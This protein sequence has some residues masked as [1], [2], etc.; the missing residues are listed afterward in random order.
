MLTFD[1]EPGLDVDL[2]SRRAAGLPAPNRRIPGGVRYG[3]RGLS[4]SHDARIKASKRGYDAAKGISGRKR[5]VAVDSALTI[6]I[7]AASKQHRDA[8]RPLM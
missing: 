2:H 3:H 7:T 1:V 8:V 4:N 6:R 5:H